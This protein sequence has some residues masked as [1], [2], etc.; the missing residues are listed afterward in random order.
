M[1]QSLLLVL[2]FSISITTSAQQKVASKESSQKQSSSA[3]VSDGRIFGIIF[4]DYS[5]VIQ[6]PQV[7]N[8]TKTTSGKNSFGFRRG[9]IGYEYSF[10]SNVSA[11]IMYDASKNAFQ[12]GNV[13][14]KN[15]VPYLDVTMGMMQNPSSETVEKIWNYR[16]LGQTVLDRLSLT[17]EFDAGITFTGKS[18]NQGTMYARLGVFNGNGAVVDSNKLKKMTL[19]IGNWFN[20]SSIVEIYADYENI[21]SGKSRITAKIFYGVVIPKFTFGIEGF[22][23]LNRSD[24]TISGVKKDIVPVGGS[25]YAKF[26]MIKSLHGILRVDGF[27]NDLNQANIGFRELYVNAGIDYMPVPEVHLIPNVEY[28]KQLKK[29]TTT[30]K[31]DYITARLTAAVYFPSFK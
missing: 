6:E 25:L 28:T 9:S 2:L 24:T 18:N 21:G 1:K 19:S 31:A 14:V 23:R 20:K 10:N 7:V 4:S 29:G 16:S 30:V 22:Y 26:E 3:V 15:L 5:Y 8:K 13:E 12:E 11:R 17:N 27:D